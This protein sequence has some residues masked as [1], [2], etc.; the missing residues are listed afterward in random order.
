MWLSLRITKHILLF[1]P[2][3]EVK[4]RE[5]Q[6]STPEKLFDNLTELAMNSVIRPRVATCLRTRRLVLQA[7]LYAFL[8]STSACG[9]AKELAE[10]LEECPTT[11][12]LVLRKKGR[13]GVDLNRYCPSCTHSLTTIASEPHGHLRAPRKEMIESLFQD[14]QTFMFLFERVAELFIQQH[15]NDPHRIRDFLQFLSSSNCR[16]RVSWRFLTVIVRTVLSTRSGVTIMDDI[17]SSISC[18]NVTPD[19]NANAYSLLRALLVCSDQ[20]VRNNALEEP[21]EDLIQAAMTGDW[22]MDRIRKLALIRQRLA[23]NENGT[24]NAIAE[25]A[26]WRENRSDQSITDA[27]LFFILRFSS[28]EGDTTRLSNILHDP[29]IAKELD[30]HKVVRDFIVTLSPLSL[31]FPLQAAAVTANPFQE[32][33]LHGISTGNFIKYPVLLELQPVWAPFIA[34]LAYHAYDVFVVKRI[35]LLEEM[36][37]NL[38]AAAQFLLPGM[39]N[40]PYLPSFILEANRWYLCTCDT[41]CCLGNCGRPVAQSVCDNCHVALGANHELRAGVRSATIEDFQPPSGI[42][43]TRVPVVTPNFAVRNCTPVVTRFALLLNSLALMN[44]ALNPRTQ[45][46]DICNLLLTLPPTERQPV[47]NCG[48]L[49]QLLSNHIVVHL[50]LLCQLLV[51]SRPQLTMTDKFRIGHLL[52]HK[53]LASS[54][55]SLFA[56][57]TKFKSKPQAREAF[58]N[59]LTSLLVQQTNLAEELDYVAQSDEATMAFRQSLLHSQTSFWAYARRVFSDRRCVQLELTRNNSLRLP[60]LNLLL[61]ANYMD[62][63]DALQYFGPAM[64]FLALVRT[65]MSGEITQEE[66]NGMSIAQG[67]EKMVETVGRKA[68]TLD[69]GRPVK[70]KEHVMDLFDGFKQL[71]ERFSHLQNAENKTFLDY[72]ECQQIDANVRP[73]AVLEQ[74]APLIFICAGSELPE[75]TFCYQLLNH[76][77]EAASSIALNSFIQPHCRPGCV[78][79]SCSSAAALTDFD[80]SLYAHVPAE[81]VDRFIRDHLIDQ[82]TLQ[83]AE[84]F[85]RTAILGS[86]GST[87]AENVSLAV[88][89][90]FVFKDDTESRNYLLVLERRSLKWQPSSIP[91]HLQELILADL[92]RSDQKQFEFLLHFYY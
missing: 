39:D 64:R 87:I 37:S 80:E 70:T 68:V 15:K 25:W 32:C 19:T 69:R 8:K 5:L 50:D 88:I 31:G 65:V 49:M 40:H 23:L 57:A 7:D 92:V 53:L 81:L 28:D 4:L 6:N 1:D 46:D 14:H 26:R 20:D 27:L 10:I 89:P 51:T 54:D 34:R 77:A 43:M 73:K 67:L 16:L 12:C 33:L 66:A 59:G 91:P 78:R 30:H 38:A 72:F 47:E 29:R 11:N 52:L 75:A 2:E 84:S 85:A 62:K 13:D 3:S 82:A 55:P 41:L 63:L 83:I 76:A 9:S 90:E 79:L 86:A 74:T 60:F 36:S 42:Y 35:H 44:A 71:W 58:E 17:L 18:N 22:T 56:N 24:A 61:D 45:P 48:S 21:A